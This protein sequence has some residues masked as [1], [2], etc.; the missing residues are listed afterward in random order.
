MK[1]ETPV[2]VPCTS[3]SS[4]SYLPSCLAISTTC[5][6]RWTQGLTRIIK[7]VAR[8]ES[9]TSVTKELRHS[10]SSG[11]NV[12]VV[13]LQTTFLLLRWI[14][15]E[16]DCENIFAFQGPV[17]LGLN[18]LQ[19]ANGVDWV[20]EGREE[21][22]IADAGGV[23]GLLVWHP[24]WASLWLIIVLL[25]IVIFN[26]NNTAP[27]IQEVPDKGLDPVKLLNET[28]IR[29]VIRSASWGQKA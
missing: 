3:T 17:S 19:E 23:E 7:I 29:S 20:L 11:V 12:L 25:F 4:S 15:A 1:S 16:L 5:C 22:L 9:L 26:N 21:V 2:T 24:H 28:I 18:S 27:Y 6:W 14:G 8:V 10:L 13:L